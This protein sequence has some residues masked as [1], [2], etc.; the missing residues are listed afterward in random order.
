MN[1]TILELINISKSYPGVQALKNVD[2][3]LKTGEVHVLI[4]ENGAGKSTMGNIII[5]AEK[6]NSGEIILEGKKVS[7]ERPADAI[8]H[9]IAG[10]NQELMLIPWLNGA[11]N[12][13]LNREPRKMNLPLMIDQK[14]MQ[15]D[16]ME[17][18]SSI[19][20]SS[21]QVSSPVKLMSSAQK[22]MIEIAKVL[23]MKPKIVIF[24]EPTAILSEEEVNRLFEKIEAL[25]Q[26]GAAIIYIS[27][28]LQEIRRI[29][30]RVTVL[31]DGS[32]VATMPIEE[33]TDEE[34]VRLMVGRHIT[35]LYARARRVPGKEILRLENCSCTE[36]PKNIDLVVREGEIVG[37]AGLVGSGRTEIARAI[38]GIDSFESGKYSLFGKNRLLKNHPSTMIK[39][40][41][42]FV[43]ED[44]KELG[45]SLTHSIMTNL[46]LPGIKKIFSFVYNAKR[47]ESETESYIKR[48]R[49]V[50][51]SP[52]QRVKQLSG[53]NQQKVVIGKWLVTESNFYIFDE[54]TKGIDIGAKTEVHQIMDDLANKGAG[55]LMISS[56]LPE[57][58]GISDRIYVMFR[59]RIV[60]ELSHEEA[61]QERVAQTMLGAKHE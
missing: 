26:E 56:D 9:G 37:L 11:Q 5:G 35:N 61:S 7:F 20:G 21:I 45:L 8:R 40:G 30:D 22:Q 13:F 18:L 23:V 54:P 60:Q 17:I 43:P 51:P 12:I 3:D 38:F 49:I 24:D 2:F 25:K 16:A 42:G 32:K 31:R 52:H 28:R 57:V 4:G 58:L 14:K 1:Q 53:G 55:I 48:L 15:N 50:T 27:H 41:I 47:A 46:L 6:P 29:G 36:G 33:T 39:D 19:G 44:R 59:G 34:L 10:V